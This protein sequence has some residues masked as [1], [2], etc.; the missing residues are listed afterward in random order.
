MRLPLAT[1]ETGLKT[2]PEKQ[3]MSYAQVPNKRRKILTTR[4]I[5]HEDFIKNQWCLVDQNGI[6]HASNASKQNLRK[7]ANGSHVFDPKQNVWVPRCIPIARIHQAT[8]GRWFWSWEHMPNLYEDG[9]GFSS[10]KLAKDSAIE[11][12]AKAIINP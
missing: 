7:F 6:E 2:Q 3:I 5:L 1:D 12:G 8:T 4:K 10:V 11:A 9:P